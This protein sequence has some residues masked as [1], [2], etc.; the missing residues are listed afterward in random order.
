LKGTHALV[1]LLAQ[2]NAKLR[3]SIATLL[4]PVSYRYR[5]NL[6]QLALLFGQLSL[7]TL[8]FGLRSCHTMLD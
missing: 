1:T 4:K 8:Q 3:E 7:A 5:T 6:I 2:G